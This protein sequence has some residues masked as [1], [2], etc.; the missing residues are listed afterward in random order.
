MVEGWAQDTLTC[1]HKLDGLRIQMLYSNVRWR[2]VWIGKFHYPRTRHTISQ[3][4]PM[5]KAKGRI[6]KILSRS[7]SLNGSHFAATRTINVIAD[8]IIITRLST[9]QSNI[10]NAAVYP[11]IEMMQTAKESGWF[12]VPTCL[13]RNCHVL[14]K[15][16]STGNFPNQRTAWQVLKAGLGSTFNAREL[17]PTNRPQAQR[18]AKH[19]MSSPSVLQRWRSADLS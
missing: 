3:V 18:L 9:L 14:A 8:A 13:S 6:I 16:E 11:T 10:H 15:M 1:V 4:R 7:V 5:F 19:I 17:I 2:S 12:E